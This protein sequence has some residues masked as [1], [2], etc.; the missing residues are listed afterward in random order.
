MPI[1]PRLLAIAVTPTARSRAVPHGTK[2]TRH[3][4]ADH[5]IPLTFTT[6]AYLLKL[7][8][9]INEVEGSVKKAE[10]TVLDDNDAHLALFDLLGAI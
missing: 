3:S 5:N 9:G 2:E 8:I 6:N 7:Q 10:F 4:L 1:A